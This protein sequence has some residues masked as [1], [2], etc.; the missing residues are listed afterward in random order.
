M[1]KGAKTV[2]WAVVIVMALVTIVQWI[3]MLSRHEEKADALR[4]LYE[5]SLLQVELLSGFVGEAADVQSTA[6]L[7]GLKQ[8]AYS[9]DFTHSRLVRAGG[10]E[11]PSL[12]SVAGLMDVVVRL[13]IGGGRKLSAEERELFTAAAPHFYEL[14]QAYGS[15]LPETGELD[16][17]AAAKV[18]ETDAAIMELIAKVTAK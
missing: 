12:T 1:R 8:A 16:R 10:S 11:W 7:N 14:Q 15:L 4:M 2:L 13:Q 6:D 5:V 9:V 18:R 17:A 3:G